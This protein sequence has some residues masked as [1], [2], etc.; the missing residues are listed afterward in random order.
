MYHEA[1]WLRETNP[2]RVMMF[3]MWLSTVRTE[4]TRAAAI[5]GLVSPFAIKAAISCCRLVSAG[6]S[7]SGIESTTCSANA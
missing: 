5:C 4:I 3:S 1:I 6:G 7:S 2:R